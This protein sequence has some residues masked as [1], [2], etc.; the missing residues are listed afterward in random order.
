MKTIYE[1]P[2]PIGDNFLI[3]MP[4]GAKILTVQT[5]NDVP[6]LWA[7]VDTEQFFETRY[8]SL[9][10]TGHRISDDFNGVYIGTFQIDGGQFVFHLF[11][12]VKYLC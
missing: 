9:F 11:E 1:Y 10:G 12:R 8:F 4:I 3:E 2:I 6:Q 7:S 5:Q